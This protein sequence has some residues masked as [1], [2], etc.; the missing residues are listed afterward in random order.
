MRDKWQRICVEAC[1]QSQ[2]PWLP[3]IGEYQTI[4]DFLEW[5]SE[6]SEITFF[7]ADGSGER[8]S[9]LPVER[10]VTVILVGPEGGFSS[11]EVT[12]LQSAGISPVRLSTAILRTETAAISAASQFYLKT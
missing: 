11:G 7:Y 1:K 5:C 8:L 10:D 9:Q 4:R 2:N 3:T 6:Q 12:Q